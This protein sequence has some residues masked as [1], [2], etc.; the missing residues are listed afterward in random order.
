MSNMS[1]RRI[2]RQLSRQI[3]QDIVL[4]ERNLGQ[5]DHK[6]VG[7]THAVLG[8]LT[9]FGITNSGRFITLC[10]SVPVV[11]RRRTH[12]PGNDGRLWRGRRFVFTCELTHEAKV[13]DGTFRQELFDHRS[14]LRLTVLHA[15]T[16]GW[17]RPESIENLQIAKFPLIR[18]DYT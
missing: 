3:E 16:Y 15:T 6:E 1:K 14:N 18:G 8:T 4:I 7:F 5:R 17:V 12:G 9:E 2:E 11:K 13:V 10:L